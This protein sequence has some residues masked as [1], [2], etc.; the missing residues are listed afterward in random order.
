MLSLRSVIRTMIHNP[1]DVFQRLPRWRRRRRRRRRR[2]VRVRPHDEVVGQ[3]LRQTRHPLDV[4]QLE[5]LK[6]ICPASSIRRRPCAFAGCFRPATQQLEQSKDHGV[7]V[8]WYYDR[9]GCGCCYALVV[10]ITMVVV[11]ITC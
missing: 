2:R 1:S 10:A 6:E 8:G 5:L 3:Q 4:R 11:L 9:C 7:L